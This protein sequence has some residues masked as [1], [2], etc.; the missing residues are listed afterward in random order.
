MAVDISR[1][2]RSVLSDAIQ[3]AEAL[4]QQGRLTEAALAWMNA[5][6]QVEHFASMASS[7]AERTR[8]LKTARD[9]RLKSELIQKQQGEQKSSAPSQTDVIG[10]IDEFREAARRVI[11]RST[12]TFAEIIGLEKTCREIQA[13]FAFGMARRP[14]KVQIPRMNNLLFYGPPGC[15]KTLMAAAISNESGYTFFSVKVSDLMSRYYGDSP[16][17]VQALYAEARQHK[18]SVIFLDEID[19]IASGRSEGS[20]AADQKLLVSL[21]TELDG[22]NDKNTDTEIRTI[23]ATNRPWELDSA[24]LSRFEKAVYI[25]LPD[26]DARRHLLD[27]HLQQKGYEVAIPEAELLKFTE[28]FS[29]REIA[30]LS[31]LM[32]EAMLNETNPE[33]VNLMKQGADAIQD[34]EICVSAID[35]QHLDQVRDYIRPRTTKEMIEVFECW[36]ESTGKDKSKHSR[37]EEK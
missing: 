30:H 11:H 21:L 20:S 23:A 31:K 17:L 8:R 34:Y 37:N 27:T 15:G 3:K 9:L 18:K 12:V 35:R 1:F 36:S 2:Q 6:Q 32:T 22:L 13:A 16:K 14:K 7:D 26:E 4:Q 33:I 24:I 25:P 19:A 5:A 28:G 29:G 10:E